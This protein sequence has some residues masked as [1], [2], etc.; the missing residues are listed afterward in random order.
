MSSIHKML[1]ILS[2][3]QLQQVE[4]KKTNEKQFFLNEKKT[5]DPNLYLGS[6]NHLLLLS[7]IFQ[8]GPIKLPF[9]I[10]MSPQTGLN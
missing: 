1:S 5:F 10:E 2:Q 7:S 4:E 8:F 3:F 6:P 9:K